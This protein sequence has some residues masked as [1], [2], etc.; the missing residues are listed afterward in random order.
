[1][2]AAV[3]L[4]AGQGRRM[5]E[6]KGLL[7]IAGVPALWHIV[8]TARASGVGE[9]VAVIGPPH[10]AQVHKVIEAHRG[11]GP[12]ITWVWNAQ[13]ERGMLSSVKLGLAGLSSGLDGVLIWPVDVPMV[14]P[15]TTARLLDAG[16]SEPPMLTI[17]SVGG[18]AG[19]P[20][21]LPPQALP[22]VHALPEYETLRSLRSM[23]P[24]RWVCV[25]DE[26]VTQNW[27][28]QADRH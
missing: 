22:A 14:V 18:R 26:G 12:A 4:A 15:A 8:Q 20:I 11:V 1:M 21:W 16:R 2:H 19:H 5:G 7:S 6:A 27:N 23:L 28:T 3:I 10:G 17:P 24:V 25:D 9:V 13:P